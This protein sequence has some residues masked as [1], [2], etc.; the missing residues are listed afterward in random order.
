M[1]Q[2][3][4]FSLSQSYIVCTPKPKLGL[5]PNFIKMGGGGGGG[6]GLDKTSTFRGGCWERGGDFFSVGGGGGGG[7]QLSH[8]KLK[9]EIFND[10]KS[11]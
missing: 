11:L 9:C 10:K 1:T 8:N 5:Q 2:V 3:S 4:V 6:G 7:V